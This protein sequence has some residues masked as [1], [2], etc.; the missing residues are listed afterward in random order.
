MTAKFSLA[1]L[2]VLGTTPLELIE[3]AANAG[4]DYASIRMTAVAP[5]E[6]ITSMAGDPAM[7][8]RVSKRLADTGMA[9]KRGQS[10][11]AS[12]ANLGARGGKP[13]SKLLKTKE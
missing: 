3:I 5:G 10:K 4:Y 6:R 8:R 12:V 13:R 7:T 9:K 2:T 11:N 1:H